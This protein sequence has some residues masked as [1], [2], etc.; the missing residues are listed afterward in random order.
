MCVCVCEKETEKTRVCLRERETEKTRVCV[1]ERDI[2]EI[3]RIPI[4]QECTK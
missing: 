1:R 2:S 4:E 3:N